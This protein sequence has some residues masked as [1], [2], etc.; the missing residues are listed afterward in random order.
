MREHRLVSVILTNY[1]YGRFLQE[2]IDSALNQ[3]YPRTEVIVVDDGST[4]DSREIIASYGGR[5]T[6]VLKENGGQA[7]AFNTGMRAS[8]GEV[9][10]FLDSDDALLPTAVEQAADLLRD[11]TAAKAHWPLWE[12]DEHGRKTGR[13]MPSHTL[14]EGHLRERIR[15]AG[16]WSYITPPTTGNAWARTFLESV[17]P[18]PEQE[19]R[20]CADAYLFALA[21]VFGPVRR[22]LE[23]Q[24]YYRIHGTSNFWGKPFEQRLMRALQVYD[25]Q[26]LA[27]TRSFADMGIAV[28]PEA[29]KGTSWLH[30]VHAATEQVTQLV[31]AADAFILVDQEQWGTGETLSGRRRIRFLEREG[32]YW[33]PPPDDGT[34]IRELERQRRAGAGFIVFGWPAFWWLD[35]YA[36]FHRHLRS[37]FHCVL[38]NERVVAFDLRP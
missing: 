32:Q 34:A 19:Y 22:I 9:I 36:E 7:A 18:I 29:W 30:R 6:P 3:T 17:F 10:C 26:C 5:I 21:P 25:Q 13:L 2:A 24:G 15:Q 23:P 35:H 28:E 37:R 20:T 38:E 16:P 11:P 14:S 4:D 8:R 12:V 33:G 1:N 27:L 31:P